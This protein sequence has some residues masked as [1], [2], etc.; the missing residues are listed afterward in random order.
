MTIADNGKLCNSCKKIGLQRK[1]HRIMPGEG[2]AQCDEHFRDI[3]GLPQLNEE[4]KRFIEMCKAR[5]VDPNA[6]LPD[7]PRPSY[8]LEAP[9]PMQR[10]DYEAMPADRDAGMKIADIAKKHDCSCASVSMGTHARVDPQPKKRGPYKRKDKTIAVSAEAVKNAQRTFRDMVNKD[11]GAK[12]NGRFTRVVAT[13]KEERAQFAKDL[14]ALDEAIAN[15][16]KL[17]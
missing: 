14:A 2:G 4:A 3:S 12:K 16:E 17:T 10:L 8:T 7:V 1:A 5:A 9:R 13:L 15:L 6:E 11:A